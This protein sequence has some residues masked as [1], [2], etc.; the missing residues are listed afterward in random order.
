MKQNI[1]QPLTP[2]KKR[3]YA[4]R[5]VFAVINGNTP[6]AKKARAIDYPQ[7][8][9]DY[10]FKKA[11]I[12][13]IY[14]SKKGIEKIHTI[15][16]NLF[17]FQVL[18]WRVDQIM[19]LAMRK[20][21]ET[22]IKAILSMTGALRLLGIKK[23]AIILIASIQAGF[24]NFEAIYN[25]LWPL[26]N[27][28]FSSKN[29]LDICV[30]A[31]S[32]EVFN[33]VTDAYI[34]IRNIK[35]AKPKTVCIQS[36]PKPNENDKPCSPTQKAPDDESSP[37]LQAAQ[38]NSHSEDTGICLSSQ[39]ELDEELIPVFDYDRIRYLSSSLLGRI[40]LFN[41]ISDTKHKITKVWP[42][43]EPEIAHPIVPSRK[44]I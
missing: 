11:Q 21:S 14:L 42:L 3:D 41:A 37:P 23:E 44:N 19:R 17:E 34:D 26:K 6:P 16:H 5:E 1:P 15:L 31:D 12:E 30:R 36:A 32:L 24:K 8:L 20:G 38:G 4:E 43:I 27:L 29:I 28:G 13:S 2:V 35:K 10:G 39:S 7:E 40:K 25:N 9:L 33:S 22:G 18:E